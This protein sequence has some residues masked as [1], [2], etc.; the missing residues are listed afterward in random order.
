[1]RPL[2]VAAAAVT[3]VTLAVWG[4]LAGLGGDQASS[5]AALHLPSSSRA[6][7]VESK[8]LAAVRRAHLRSET[9]YFW[10]SR[11]VTLLT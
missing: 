8:E 11:H 6:G 2:Q 3:V 1:L 10:M 7:I 9:P 4:A 5:D